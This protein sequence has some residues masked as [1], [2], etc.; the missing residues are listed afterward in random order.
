MENVGLTF[1]QVSSKAHREDVGLRVA[2]S[3]TGNH[4]EGGFTPFKTIL[5][6]KD[7][8]AMQR[9]SLSAKELNEFLSSYPIPSEYDVILPT[10][11]QTIFDVPPGYVGLYTHSF[12]L[13]NLWLPLTDFF[14][15]VL[16]DAISPYVVCLVVIPL[17]SKSDPHIVEGSYVALRGLRSDSFMRFYQRRLMYGLKL[18]AYLEPIPSIY[19]CRNKMGQGLAH[20]PVIMGVSRDLRGDFLGYVPRSL[21]WREDLDRDGEPGFDL[22]SSFIEGPQRRCRASRGGFP[23][24]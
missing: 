24:W 5:S 22:C 4:P 8:I 17:G 15:E 2:N 7:T 3:H 21:F 11:T 19:R 9:C 10:S 20:R 1:A 16:Q 18:W 23:Y 13:A 14:C 12:S 6:A